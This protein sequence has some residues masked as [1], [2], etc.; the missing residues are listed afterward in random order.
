MLYL[1][2]S[3]SISLN[4]FYRNKFKF[5]LP[6]IWKNKWQ[7]VFRLAQIGNWSTLQPWVELSTDIWIYGGTC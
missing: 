5:M 4:I 2:F 7:A 6:D 1:H 3:K